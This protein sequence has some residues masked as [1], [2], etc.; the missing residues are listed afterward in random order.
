MLEILS[1]ISIYRHINRFNFGICEMQHLN[2]KGQG[3]PLT[4]RAIASRIVFFFFCL[5]I[6]FIIIWFLILRTTYIVCKIIDN[7]YIKKPYAL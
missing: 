4:D 6:A 5:D 3:A 7:S 1:D 2:N